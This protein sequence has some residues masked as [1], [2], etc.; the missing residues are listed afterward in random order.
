MNLNDRA[1]LVQLNVSQWT[2]RKYDKKAT[3][4]VASANGTVE[5][6]GRYN[7]SL[8]P[9][10]NYLGAV[11]RKTKAIRTAYYANTLPWG[12]EG[13]KML[14]SANYLSFMADFRKQSREWEDTAAKFVQQYEQLRENARG[15]LGSLYNEADYPIA[16]EVGQKFSIDMAVFPVPNTDFRVSIGSAELTRIQHDVEVRVKEAGVVAMRDV[17]QRLFDR[18]SHMAEKLSDPAA[19]FR[20]SRLENAR[21]TCDLLTRLNVMDDPELEKLRGEV[22]SRLA[23]HHPD[24][25]RNDPDKRREHA[26]IAKDIMGR[27]SVFMEGI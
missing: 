3:L 20:D 9:M 7:K 8:L 26:A 23:C 6:A 16:R 4:Q 19:V 11:H 5:A 24:S 15:F 12:I 21:E 25:L 27:M 22:A 14:P 17:W 13:T 2:A 18:V 1:L 10:N